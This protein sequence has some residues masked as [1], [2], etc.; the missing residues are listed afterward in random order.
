MWSD[1]TD[2]I[3]SH[4]TCYVETTVGPVKKEALKQAFE[5]HAIDEGS[6]VWNGSSVA[7]WKA[8]KD[9]PANIGLLNYLKPK[10]REFCDTMQ[11]VICN[12]VSA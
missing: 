11:C 2:I 6:F 9:V 5:S 10:P 1:T 4:P 7:D 8:I 3:P 12:C